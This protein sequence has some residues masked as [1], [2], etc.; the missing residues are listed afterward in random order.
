MEALEKS[1]KDLR[2]HVDGKIEEALKGLENS[3]TDKVDPLLKEE[4]KTISGIIEQKEAALQKGLDKLDAQIQKGLISKDRAE[5]GFHELLGEQVGSE[6]FKKAW[7]STNKAAFELE[8][9]G[10]AVGTMTTSDSLTGEVIAPDRRASIVELAQRRTHI[11]SLL[12]QGTMTSDVF[13]FNKETAGEGAADVTAEG[14]AKNQIDYDLAATDANVK[15]ITGFVKISMELLDDLPAMSDFLSRR[16]TKDIRTKEDQQLL[17]GTGAGGQ[18]TG[19]NQ[20]PTTFAA[21]YADSTATI[22]DLMINVA[23]VLA[24]LNYEA[25]GIL[26]NPKDY[27]QLFTA[28]SSQGEYVINTLLQVVNNQMFIAGIPV[29]MNTAVT[30]GTYFVGDWVN[31][32]QIFDRMGVT[33]RFS[34]EDSDNFTKNLVTVRA[35]ERFAFPIYYPDSFVYG[36]IATDIAKIQNF[37]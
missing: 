18:F 20:A 30:Q 19:L 9:T 7:T 22:I 26:L 8:L 35:E 16:L 34:E 25:N 13:R 28:K 31:G 33:V 14:A 6:E 4:I 17:Y 24:D 11:R 2:T 36:T 12:P 15:K 21:Y 3:I 1:I 23:A 37:T 32:A 27:Y 29:F 10:K 5:K